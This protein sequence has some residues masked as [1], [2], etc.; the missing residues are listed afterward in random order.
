MVL[1]VMGGEGRFV[2]GSCAEGGLQYDRKEEGGGGA[3][4]HRGAGM[5]DETKTKF[6]SQNY[7]STSPSP[8][9]H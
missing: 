6:K 7:A 1:F 4:G 8:P 3:G 2:G 9:L 5:I